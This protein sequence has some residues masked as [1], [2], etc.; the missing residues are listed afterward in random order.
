MSNQPKKILFIEDEPALQKTLSA[1]FAKEGF[2]V[3]EAIDGE[4]GIRFAK[5]KKPDLILLDLIIPKVNGFDVLKALKKD[6]ETALIPVIVLS[7]LE[8]VNNVQEVIGR[9]ASDYLV[10]TSYRLEDVVKK[11]RTLLKL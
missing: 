1:V 2:E 9:G 5:E 8:D 3:I 11:T 6:P 10:K 4:I 7:N